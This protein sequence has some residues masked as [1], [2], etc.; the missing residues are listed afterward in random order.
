MLDRNSATYL[1]VMI[2]F[3]TIDT[4]SGFNLVQYKLNGLY[5]QLRAVIQYFPQKEAEVNKLKTLQHM[6]D[7]FYDLRT[8]SKVPKSESIII[9]Q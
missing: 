9:K 2:E 3:I 1:R 6:V 4:R 5:N 7:E 8:K